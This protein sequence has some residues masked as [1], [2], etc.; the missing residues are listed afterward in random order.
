MFRIDA[1]SR[2]PIYE[3]IISQCEKFIL[4]GT[5]KPGDQIPSVRSLSVELSINP[6]TILKA[7]SQ[8]DGRGLIHSVP[9]RGYFVCDDAEK[10]LAETKLGLIDKIRGMAYELALAGIPESSVQACVSE[11]YRSAS[12]K[13]NI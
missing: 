3:Q 12:E 9:G 6:V 10:A 13:K 7:Y 4:T 11:G 5:L 8:L 2:T 1:M